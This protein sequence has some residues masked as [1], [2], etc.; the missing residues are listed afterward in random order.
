LAAAPV[1]QRTHLLIIVDQFEELLTRAAPSAR[2]TFSSLLAPALRG[3][4]R[5]VATLRSEFVDTLQE[6]ELQRL[7]AHLFLLNPLDSAMLPAVIKEPAHRAGIEIP[8]TLVDRLV[9]DTAGG[10]ALPLLAFTLNRLADGVKRGGELSMNRYT[11]LG[12]VTETLRGQANEALAY[13][14]SQGGRP[15]ARVID[16]ILKL[17]KVDADDRPIRSRVARDDLS[18]P[19][20]EDLEAFVDRRL[21]TS[22]T[23]DGRTYI[24]ISHERFLSEWPPLKAEISARSATLR[25]RRALE[26]AA[27]DWAAAGRPRSHL[28]DRK[29]IIA[30]FA[31][32]G[33]T[34][35]A[36]VLRTARTPGSD[37]PGLPAR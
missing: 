34:L 5:V 16:S 31:L 21:L 24:S 7:P 12:G 33:G 17:V 2:V 25:A 3:P 22:Y 32:G 36:R 26:Q 9:A 30:E 13:R 10:D 28:W 4:V 19:V 29:R 27:A 6:S 20:R 11:E 1:G 8:R 18:G 15:D 14:T 37:R 35:S 23:E